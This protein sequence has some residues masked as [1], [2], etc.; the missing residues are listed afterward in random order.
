MVVKNTIQKINMP[1]AK[2]V[3]MFFIFFMQCVLVLVISGCGSSMPKQI[4]A[5]QQGELRIRTSAAEHVFTVELALDERSQAKG[6]MFRREMKSDHGMLFIYK[7]EH[8]ISMWMKNTVLS[9]DMLFV[10]RDGTIAKIAK[11]TE[12]FS[13]RIIASREPVL[14][15]L[16][17]NGGTADRL[18]IK[19]GDRLIHPLLASNGDQ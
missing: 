3:G 17:L 1:T 2:P 6:L 5:A 14:A 15:V 11:R 13:E 10:K 8:P 19:E 12:P 16:E 18:M 7:G 4:D 9:L